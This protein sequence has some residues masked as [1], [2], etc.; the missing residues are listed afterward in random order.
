MR[1]GGRTKL[2]MKEMIYVLAFFALM[3]AGFIAFSYCMVKG[4]ID[5]YHQEQ[6]TTAEES[7]HG[8]TDANEI[9]AEL[10]VA[11]IGTI[12][13]TYMQ[14]SE[15][16][17]TSSN[18]TEEPEPEPKLKP[19]PPTTELVPEQKPA[20]ES[21]LE[22]STP[23]KTYD[24]E[25]YDEKDESS[26]TRDDVREIV[27]DE[28]GSSKKQQKEEKNIWRDIVYII[29]LVYNA[30]III[31]LNYKLSGGKKRLPFQRK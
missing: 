20:T 6:E 3:G 28:I 16:T 10:P 26:L 4:M 5:S 9:A 13:E 19:E 11:Q 14:P 24:V 21:L 23:E 25:H 8:S 27:R 22:M 7:E 15:P 12:A 29:I 17:T 31:D 2:H 18:T 1:R 30:A